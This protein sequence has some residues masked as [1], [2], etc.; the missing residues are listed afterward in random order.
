MNVRQ[1]TV[2]ARVFAFLTIALSVCGAARAQ[3]LEEPRI[4]VVDVQR[5]LTE[6]KASKGIQPE[7][8]NLRKEFQN[9]VRDEERALRE[10]EQQLSQ[11]RAI[12]SP[13]A[14]AQKRREFADKAGEAQRLVQER[15][16]S[17]DRAFNETRNVII[18]N[19]ALVTQDIARERKLNIVLDKKFT[20]MSANS[21]D[22]TTE[23]IARLDKKLPKVKIEIEPEANAKG[24]GKVKS[25]Q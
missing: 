22:I 2:Y 12:L 13:D 15:R 17:I 10:A 3:T 4:A 18:Q 24:N 23:V 8:E 11:Q 6:A 7:L 9:K 5:I 16:K 21:L 1:M 25:K 14:F 19:L 20:F